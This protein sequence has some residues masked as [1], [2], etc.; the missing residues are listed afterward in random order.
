MNVLLTAVNAKYIH[1]NLAVYALRAAAGKYNG[2]VSIA[3]FTIN[4]EPD[5]VLG[6]LMRK[7]PDVLCFSVYIWNLEYVDKLARCVHV[8]RPELPIWVGGPEVSFDTEEFLLAHPWATGVMSGE[9]EDTFRELCSHY[10]EPAAGSLSSVAGLMFR[11]PDPSGGERLCRTASRPPVDL[12]T[13]PFPYDPADDFTNRILYYESMR[14]CPFSCAYCLSSVEHGTRFRSP[15]KVFRDLTFFLDRRVKQVKFVD[16]TFNCDRERALRVWKFLAERDN[17]VTGFHFEIAADLLREEDTAFLNTVRPG[18][19]QLEI[20]VQSAN[21]DTLRAIHR[22]TSLE[23]V[24]HSVRAIKRGGNVLQHLDLIAGLPCEDFDS[25]HRSF[26]L[27]YG[28]KPEQL[29]LGFLKV[30]KGTETRRTAETYACSYR[31]YPPY[32]ILST[33]WLSFE[34]LCCLK[35]TEEMLEVYYNSGQYPV[36]IRLLEKLIGDAFE[37]FR[38]LGDFYLEQ[39]LL[40][41]E[42]SRQKRCSILLNFADSLLEGRPDAPEMLALLR[43]AALFDLY[44]RENCKPRPEWAPDPTLR[45]EEIRR[46][47]RSG[48]FCHV[49]PFRYRFPVSF[50]TE[51]DALP[52]AEAEPVW[53]TFDYTERDP[54]TRQAKITFGLPGE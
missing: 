5:R 33:K 45:S 20:G 38:R 6:E 29:Q 52:A 23:R 7:A 11:E 15:E 22:T 39:G 47:C 41:P 31:P 3:E 26:N 21:P 17:G 48:K 46:R 30:L 37:T 44:A 34:E 32:E 19:I 13:A 42:H 1:S 2:S 54:L 27:V 25:F 40:G 28:W 14:G 24:E 10:V 50:R 49:E 51:P 9:G 16:R 53:V 18:L 12:D 8:L 43:E 36:T 35:R 4:Q